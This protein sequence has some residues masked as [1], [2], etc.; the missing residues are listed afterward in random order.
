[1]KYQ[2][3]EQFISKPRLDRFLI[4][5]GNSKT[6]AQK[7]Y[8]INLRVSQEPYP[9][10]NLFEI[11]IRNAINAQ[12]IV[13]FADADWIV[14]QKAHFMSNPSLSRS[15][16]QMRH[17]VQNAEAAIRRK[18]AAVTAGKVIAEQTFGFWTS[19][20]ETHHFR[21]IGGAPLTCFA[22]KPAVENR[23]SIAAKLND[24]RQFRNRVYHN[25][26]IC[27]LNCNPPGIR[28]GFMTRFQI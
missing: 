22:N 7:L 26:P 17:S 24:I 18:G 3:L 13:Q 19:L 15:R 5:C 12:M 9:L 4:A 23:S 14:N 21:L 6:K 1:M 20:F 2:Q 8:K 10:L 27:F 16:F 28:T 25:E 11:F